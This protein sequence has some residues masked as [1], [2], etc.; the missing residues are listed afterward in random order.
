[1]GTSTTTPD[2]E[3]GLDGA[4]LAPAREVEAFMGEY[5]DACGLPAN[6]DEAVRY[7]LLA[8]G[9]RMRPLLAAHCCV[10]VGGSVNDCLPAG[11]SVEMIHAFSL[12][13][14]DLPALDDDDLRRGR[15]TLHRA[16]GEA[17]A[18][19]AGDVLMSLA[20]Q[21]LIERTPD[22]AL[23]ARLVREIGAGTTSMIAG[24]VYDTLGGFAEGIDEE[25]RLRL[26][27]DNKTG[28]LLTAACRMGAL[29]G[30]GPGVDESKLEAVT[31]YG[32]CVGLMFQ[33]VDDLLDVEQTTEHT[34]KRTAKDG[35]AGK[36]TYP[37][38]VGVEASR[39]EIERLL[40]EAREA[41]GT[42]G[43]RGGALT[44]IAEFLAVRTR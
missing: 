17:M 20:F 30:M 21:V 24:Q 37:R 1:M 32:A 41:S 40:A 10:A 3:T 42:F 39:R 18:I 5:L 44:R 27:H 28:A 35:D 33:I 6:L 38:L 13:H 8:G 29:S 19:L 23:G 15:P 12:V 14:D 22:P 36:L 25:A 11:A 16:H 4:L 9:K 43:S 7:A 26:I 2:S 31:R 34:G